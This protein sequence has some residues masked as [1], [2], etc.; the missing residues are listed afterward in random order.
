MNKTGFGVIGAGIV[1]GGLHAH[2]YHHLPQAELIAVCDLNIERAR[3]V[4]ERYGAP[5]VYSDYSELLARDDISAVSIAT[6][7]FAHRA[8]A[9]AAAEAGKHILVEKA[10][11]DNE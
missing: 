11:G 7:D 4:A 2:V 9:V 3:K 5:Y 6:P 10:A 8:I 1:G